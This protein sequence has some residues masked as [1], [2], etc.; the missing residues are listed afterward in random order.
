[1]QY[2]ELIKWHP[3][4]A[5][6]IDTHIL[7]T[8]TRQHH[9]HNLCHRIHEIKQWLHTCVYQ[10]KRTSSNKLKKNGSKWDKGTSTK[11]SSFITLRIWYH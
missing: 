7:L 3:K 1:M 8:S 5:L 10:Q 2:R 9:W 6:T 4:K 11:N